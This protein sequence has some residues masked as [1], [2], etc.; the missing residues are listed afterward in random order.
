MNQ[1]LTDWASVAEIISGIA[2]VITLIFLVQG[3]RENT[4]IVR[5]SVYEGLIQEINA[6]NHDRVRDPEVERI[7][8][9][10]FSGDIEA[11]DERDR[12]R[13]I[14]FIQALFRTYERAYFSRQYGVIGEA[15]WPNGDVSNEIYVQISE[16]PESS[17]TK[18]SGTLS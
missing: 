15:E 11:L 7:V 10:L 5:V 3:I 17:V 9:V 12:S 18:W 4:A 13:L 16:M 6:W 14:T 1:K 2:V 8:S